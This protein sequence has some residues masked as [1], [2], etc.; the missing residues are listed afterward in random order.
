MRIELSD[1]GTYFFCVITFNHYFVLQLLHSLYYLLW[2][3]HYILI[4]NHTNQNA[5]SEITKAICMH[6]FWDRCYDFYNI[7][8]EKFGKKAFLTQK[9][10]KLCKILIIMV[11][12]KTPIFCRKLWKIAENCDHNIDP[13]R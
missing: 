7:F 1:L 8:A 9:E 6:I 2:Q 11:L 13:W 4:G 10:A 3:L 5:K 12:R